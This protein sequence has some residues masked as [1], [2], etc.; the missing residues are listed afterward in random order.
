MSDSFTASKITRP[1]LNIYYHIPHSRGT[2]MS[3]SAGKLRP[4]WD[5]HALLCSVSPMSVSVWAAVSCPMAWSPQV[6]NLSVCVQ[7]AA[8]N[9]GPVM[10]KYSHKIFTM[11]PNISQFL[12]NEAWLVTPMNQCHSRHM[13]PIFELHHHNIT[14]SAPMTQMWLWGVRQP[15]SSG[16]ALTHEWQHF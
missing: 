12:T 10:T 2:T 4:P 5:G 13:S 1:S 8:C 11:S 7:R 16:S 9:P 14:I 6:L 15:Q 3:G